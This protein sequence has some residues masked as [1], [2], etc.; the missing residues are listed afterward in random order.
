MNLEQI[1]KK[2]NTEEG[3]I[4]KSRRNLCSCF[5]SSNKNNAIPFV[6]HIMK[7]FRINM[8]ALEHKE[9]QTKNQNQLKKNVLRSS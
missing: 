1:K 7:S 2:E 8:L 5:H 9:T 6:F 3:S 4:E